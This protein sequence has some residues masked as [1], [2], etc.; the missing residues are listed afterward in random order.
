MFPAG[1]PMETQKVLEA[2]YLK[3]CQTDAAKAF[4]TEK[5]VILRALNLQQSSTLRDADAKKVG[6]S[7]FDS[8]AA[9]NSP[10]KFG[11]SR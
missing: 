3:A 5:G 4:A 2:A 6:W 8:G 7:L 11:V 9:P 10:E 1:V